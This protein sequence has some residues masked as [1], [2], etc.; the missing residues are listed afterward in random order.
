[1]SGLR[2]RVQALFVEFEQEDVRRVFLVQFFA[3]FV[4]HFALRTNR[5]VVEGETESSL[6]VICASPTRSMMSKMRRS[7]SGL[8]SRRQFLKDEDMG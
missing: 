8:I 6:T 5:F 4:D 7:R 3:Q 1:M 2:A